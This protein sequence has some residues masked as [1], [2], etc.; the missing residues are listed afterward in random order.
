MSA[1]EWVL[2]GGMT[3][4]TFLIR[5]SFFAL[6]E[7]LRFPPLARRALRFVPAAVLTAITVPMVLVPDGTH[8]QLPWRNPWLAGALVSGWIAWR[9][10]HLLGA[11]GAGMAVYFLGRVLLQ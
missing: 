3:L 10:N 6:G 5:Y 11:I 2:V 4:V 1:R 8:W 9:F 7:R